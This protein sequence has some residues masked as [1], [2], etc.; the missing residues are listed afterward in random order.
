[1]PDTH[2]TN[3]RW[4]QDKLD[5]LNRLLDQGV[6]RESCAVRFQC[7][8][9]TITYQVGKLVKM[10]KRV[11]GTR[12]SAPHW[13]PDRQAELAKLVTD[14]PNHTRQEI[15]DLMGVTK[16]SIAGQVHRLQ[17]KGILKASPEAA[18]RQRNSPKARRDRL[19][20]EAAREKAATI[21]PLKSH[22]KPR[23]KVP[24]TYS[25]SNLPHKPR[26][27]KRATLQ[28]NVSAGGDRLP[29]TTQEQTA[30]R[31]HKSTHLHAIRTSGI[32]EKTVA[33]R[34]NQCSDSLA[35][36]GDH[37]RITALGV[38]NVFAELGFDL[39]DGSVL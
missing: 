8:K 15:A 21:R 25:P 11:G 2:H 5:K 10:G 36:A 38:P 32:A 7:H 26:S 17:K 28:A 14:N 19:T 23:P 9:N 34:A 18:F 39:G 33:L 20:R 6:S 24:P 27:H 29:R 16:N 3:E 37:N 13:T 22:R 12:P 4:T 1:M 31:L 30:H 35:V